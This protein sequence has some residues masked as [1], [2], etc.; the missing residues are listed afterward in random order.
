MP[1]ISRPAGQSGAWF[2]P[3]VVPRL[4][5]PRN[6]DRDLQ[7]H[8]HRWHSTVADGAQSA[9]KAIRATSLH[10]GTRPLQCRLL[11]PTPHRPRL[12]W[13][14]CRKAGGLP[15]CVRLDHRLGG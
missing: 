13:L 11:L 6:A 3:E 15:L 7:H 9:V 10:R 4:L 2:G 14:K 1:R 8:N 5:P 12:R